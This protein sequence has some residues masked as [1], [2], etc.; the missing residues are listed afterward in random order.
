MKMISS[1][2]A[3][4]RNIIFTGMWIMLSSLIAT[5]SLRI[6]MDTSGTHPSHL[7]SYKYVIMF[8]GGA[9]CGL[10]L[11]AMLI[12]IKIRVTDDYNKIKEK[13]K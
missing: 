4:L 9:G 8:V 12:A 10:F 2:N 7:L 1:I 5:I 6:Y 13:Y 3:L 11:Y